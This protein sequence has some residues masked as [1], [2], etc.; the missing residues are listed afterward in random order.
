ME[1][2]SRPRKIVFSLL[3]CGLG[4]LALE[5]VLHLSYAVIKQRVFPVTTYDQA[6]ARA[7]DEAVTQGGQQSGASGR[8]MEVV[9][10]YLGFVLDP[11][12]STNTSYLGFPESEDDPFTRT[13]GVLNIAILGGSFAEGL[14]RYG[15]KTLVS[16]LKQRGVEA[17]ILTV[18]MGGYKQP[19]PL[20]AL[21]YLF[22][23]GAAIDA[24]VN[25]DGFNEVALP[26]AEN[27]PSGVSP[28]FPRNWYQRTLEVEDRAT[29]RQI[30]RALIFQDRRRAWAKSCRLLPRS[31]IVRNL[32]W[33]ALDKWLVGKIVETQE[34]IRR[35]EAPVTPSFRAAG[36]VLGPRQGAVL[37]GRIAEHWATCSMMMKSLCEAR[38]IPY[39]HALQ[40]NQYVEGSKTLT[41]EELVTAFREDH[42][43]RIGVVKGYPELLSAG[44]R[45]RRQ[46]VDFH[47]LTNLYRETPQTVYA[48][49]C[50]HPNH[51]GYAL[52]AKEI[53]GLLAPKLKP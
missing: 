15:E 47:D 13:P 16:E 41:P 19:Q 51:K 43:Y 8:S 46:G 48:D 45:L 34:D 10:P 42:P 33:R 36:P 27:L 17:R 4:W 37:Y 24:V 44:E 28:F 7:A 2:I 1:S 39:L 5:L 11:S 38:N 14:S 3:A 22:S 29:L 20:F 23:H 32:I 49:D 26:G 18:A 6:M 30:G 21:T 40:P 52:V 25:L 53:A 9:H 31:S 12:R 50:C 35:P